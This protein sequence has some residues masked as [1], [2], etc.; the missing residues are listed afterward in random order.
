MELLEGKVAL[1]TG[2]TSGVGGTSAVLFAQE[3]AKVVF[4][5]RR[6]RGSWGGESA[7]GLRSVSRRFARQNL[8]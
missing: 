7:S 1:V 2:G 4:T 6:A 3:G 5:D 8:H